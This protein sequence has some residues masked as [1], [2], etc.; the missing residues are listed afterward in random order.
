[1]PIVLRPLDRIVEKWRSRATAALTDYSEGVQAPRNP[2]QKQAMAASETWK[3]A[4]TDAAARDAYRKG[5]AATSEE[6]WRS[7]ALA[8]GTARFTDGVSKSVDVFKGKWAPF[9][10]VLSRIELPPRGPRGDPKN[11]ERVRAIMT[12]LRQKK[13]GGATTPTA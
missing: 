8:L 4:I 3:A 7:R 13:L 10:D 1:M 12:A 5:V 11:V 9:Y 6:F 2:W